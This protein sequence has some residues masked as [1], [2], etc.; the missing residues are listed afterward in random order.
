MEKSGEALFF[1]WIEAFQAGVKV[2]GG[3]GWNL[4]RLERYGF[5]VPVGGVL[6][7]GAYQDFG[8]PV[9]RSAEDSDKAS[10][11]GLDASV[12]KGFSHCYAVWIVFVPRSHCGLGV[13]N[14]GGGE[15]TGRDEDNRRWSANYW[16]FYFLNVTNLF[17]MGG[18]FRKMWNVR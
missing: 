17:H 7:A 16:P 2:V 10:F 12:P 15:H 1:S 8:Y 4:G 5:N 3:K 14:S 13:W 9:F 6:A 11:A 18:I